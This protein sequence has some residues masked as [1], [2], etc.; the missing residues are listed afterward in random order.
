MLSLLDSPVVFC[1][2]D[3]SMATGPVCK[4][5]W[6]ETYI[7]PRYRELWEIV[8]AHGKKAFFVADGNLDWALG[9][10]RGSGCD[11]IMFESPATN[12]DAVV[13]V[14][15]DAFFIGGIDAQVLSGGS[16]SDVREHVDAVDRKTR[17]HLGFAL[18]C[19]GGLVGNMPLAN[20]ESYF[21]A[22]AQHGYT[23][24]PWRCG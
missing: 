17:R 4:P 2:D 1:H 11:G 19:S 10:L 3:I 24:S 14:W 21:D 22:R 13:D 16:T 15:G 12:L 8:H 20:L 7:F 23:V 18:C 6:Y 5:S 9:A